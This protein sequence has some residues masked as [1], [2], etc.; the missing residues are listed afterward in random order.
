MN[1]MK[2][3]CIF[4]VTFWDEEDFHAETA[5]YYKADAIDYVEA[6]IRKNKLVVIKDENT[7]DR[8]NISNMMSIPSW[9][10]SNWQYTNIDI[11]PLDLYNSYKK[12]L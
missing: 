4:L 1:D 2:D 8:S 11:T 12:A 6:Y 3:I 7:Q 5:F 10:I 9:I